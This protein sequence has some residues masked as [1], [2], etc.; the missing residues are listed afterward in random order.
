MIVLYMGSTRMS[1]AKAIHEIVVVFLLSS[2]VSMNQSFS[3]HSQF[4]INFQLVNGSKTVSF[5]YC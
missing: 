3:V 1:K 2:D 4:K 5:D